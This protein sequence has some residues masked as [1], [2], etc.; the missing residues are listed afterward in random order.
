MRLRILALVLSLSIQSVVAQT[1]SPTPGPA[2]P[3]RPQAPP[4][5]AQPQTQTGTAIIK[6]RITAADTGRPLRRARVTASA[7]ELGRARDVSTDV[8]GRY[9]I[10][11]L[12]AGRYSLTVNRSGYLRLRYGQRRPLEQ[13]KQLDVAN[14]QTVDSIDFAMPKMSVIAGRVTDELGDPIEGANVFAM[15]MDYWQGRRRVVPGSQVT[16]TDD[17]GQYRITG[18]MPGAYWVMA[19]IRET[20]TFTEDGKTEVLGY[21]PSYLPGTT[22]LA[23]AMRVTVG[24]GQE[25]AV[26]D[27]PLVPGRAAK[28]SGI[29]TDARG[30][31]LAGGSIGI[32]QETVGTEG[33]MFTSVGGGSIAA[34]GTFSVLNV[35]PGEYKI[36]ATAAGNRPAGAPAEIV[37][38]VLIV[39]GQDIE[40]LRLTTTAGWSMSGRIRTESG[41]ALSVPRNRV[42]LLANLVSPDLEPRTSGMFTNSQIRDDWTFAITNI[43]GPSRLHVTVPSGWAVKAVLQGD[44]DVTDEAIDM[45]SGEQLSDVEVVV[46]NVVTR[47][48]GRLTDGEGKASAEGTVLF[49][50]AERAKWFDRSRWIRAARPDQNGTF[51][52]EGLP[53]GE[54]LAVAL[55]YVQDG[56]WNDPEYL[57]SLAPGAQKITLRAGESSS[58]PLKVVAPPAGL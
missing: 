10:K 54:Y 40:G 42:S 30:L 17:V 51:Q 46:T 12:P 43:F 8:D 1:P 41:E 20:W 9:E 26:T 34:D 50:A 23:Q 38:Q 47:V 29:A 24:L 33:G 19:T 22:N 45:S 27:F 6:G 4:R 25:A 32:S 14:G 57:A 15:R 21:A 7:P 18:L 28:V 5:D 31:P 49:F 36:R 53:A 48:T 35:P 52:I 39:D 16:R 37:T 2:A 11:D 56:V 44:R 55:D 13:G 3:P 58:V